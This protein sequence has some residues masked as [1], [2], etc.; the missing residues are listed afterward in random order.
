[1]SGMI[2]HGRKEDDDDD[3]ECEEERRDENRGSCYSLSAA[4]FES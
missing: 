1:M 4:D 2:L 3:D